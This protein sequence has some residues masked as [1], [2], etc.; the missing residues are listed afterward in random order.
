[1]R[2]GAFLGGAADGF[3]N[4]YK[5]LSEEE[6][7]ELIKEERRQA[8]E[9]KR[10]SREAARDTLGRAG[11]QVFDKDVGQAIGAGDQQARMLDQ[12]NAGF[13]PDGY[14]AAS[15]STVESG[16]YA[17]DAPQGAIP[18][19]KGRAYSESEAMGDYGRRMAAID[20][21]K[22][23]AVN[24]Q[25]RQLKQLERAEKMQS[26]FDTERDSI[27]N[28]FIK[29]QTVAET[30]NLEE[31]LKLT[32]TNGLDVRA[33][34]DE[35]TGALKL[36]LYEKGKV[37]GTANSLQDAVGQL[38]PM[39]MAQQAQR[40]GLLFSNDPREF[41]RTVM[42][43][44]RDERE[45]TT[46]GLAV[47]ADR[48]A[49]EKA[50]LERQVLQ[51]NVAESGAKSRYYDASA[52]YVD[53]GKGEDN[54]TDPNTVWTKT[55]E[56]ELIKQ[57]YKPQDIQMQKDAYFA[58]RGYAPPAAVEAYRTGKLPDGKAL[59]EQ[60][61]QAI[62][63]RYPNTEWGKVQP[64]AEAAPAAPAKSGQRSALPTGKEPPADPKVE[65]A[66]GAL[67]QA[68]ATFRAAD[69]RLR[70]YG[71]KRQKADP[72]GYLA[73][74]KEAELAKKQLREAETRYQSALPASI[75]SAFPR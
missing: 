9:T 23:I 41:F 72:V 11:T 33:T 19:M 68:R 75:K 50:P 40:F 61:R 35:K 65:A 62:I 73:A 1:M 39:Y 57:G 48:R 52:R 27:K 13:G 25:S 71:S 69:D 4:T 64:A 42:D 12:Q 37:V 60:D 22:A 58:R 17:A 8:L 28:T 51:A 18:D 45:T 6:E 14:E 36:S 46:A 31:F 21:E 63:K 32:K 30:G 7:R 26:E 5:M 24:L 15:R 49:E 54:K 44:R 43:V 47:N 29:M 38:A 67:D 20:P 2:F 74:Q 16:R 3:K 34:T 59:S 53:S 70:S 56:P 55:I 10:Q 66:G